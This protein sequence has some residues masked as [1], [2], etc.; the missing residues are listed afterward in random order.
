MKIGLAY[1]WLFQQLC[2]GNKLMPHH[3]LFGS[4]INYAAE[5]FWAFEWKQDNNNRKN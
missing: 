4:G 2:S 3:R 1:W 5:T